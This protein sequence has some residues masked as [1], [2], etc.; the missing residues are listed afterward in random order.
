MDELWMSNDIWNLPFEDSTG[1]IK[2]V[3]TEKVLTVISDFNVVEEYADVLDPE[4]PDYGNFF[5][6]WRRGI[7]NPD[8]FFNFTIHYNGSEKLLTA[9]SNE[10]LKIKGLYIYYKKHYWVCL[11]VRPKNFFCIFHHV[12]ISWKI[13]VILGHFASFG[14]NLE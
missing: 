1:F 11:S 4:Y 14:D 5:Q 12:L 3:D 2:N 9:K 6:I 8:G 10:T 13:C 7:A